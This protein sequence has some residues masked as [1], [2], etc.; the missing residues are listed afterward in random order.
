MAIRLNEQ[1]QIQAPIGEVWSFLLTPERVVTCMPGA[2]LQEVV[3]ERTF[4]GAI[5]VKVGPIITRYHGRAQLTGRDEA[6]GSVQLVAEGREKDGSGSAR[7]TMT[8]VLRALSPGLTEVS[9]EASVEITGRVMQFG[10]G[11]IEGVSRQLFQQ[12]VVCTKATLESGPEEWPS[13]D[14]A[15]KSQ[16]A[17]P[18][19]AISLALKVVWTAIV[20]FFRRL[21][22]RRGGRPQAA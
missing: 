13:T 1:F 2:E 20:A 8:S 4:L 18:V 11:M 7:G 19:E 6:S 22:G 5:K 3:D 14:V 10:R 16:E 12:F 17:K 9:V 15:L 21:L